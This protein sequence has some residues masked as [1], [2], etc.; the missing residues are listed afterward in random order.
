MGNIASTVF[1]ASVNAIAFQVVHFYS[2]NYQTMEPQERKRHDLAV[3]H[4]QAS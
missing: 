4:L 1:G 2:I 3:E